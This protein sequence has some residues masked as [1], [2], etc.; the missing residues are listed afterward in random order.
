MMAFFALGGKLPW[1]GLRKMTRK[2]KEQKIKD[3]KRDCTFSELFPGQ[4]I[5]FCEYLSICR[6]M[7]FEERPDYKRLKKMFDGI[8]NKNGWAMDY[9]YDWVIKKMEILKMQQNQAE[10]AQM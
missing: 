5:E 9:E 4:P 2:D 7:E 8:M 10:L 3:L 1:M 6:N